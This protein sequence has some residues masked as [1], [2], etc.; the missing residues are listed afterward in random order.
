MPTCRGARRWCPQASFHSLCIFFL[1]M[2]SMSTPNK[3]GNYEDLVM[4]GT[5][6]YTGMIVTVNL[7]V[8]T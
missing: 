6:V 8:M 7:K 1:P 4:I 3:S 5:T 2:Y